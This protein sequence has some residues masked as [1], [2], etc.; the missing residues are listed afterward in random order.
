MESMDAGAKQHSKAYRLSCKQILYT[1]GGNIN[2]LAKEAVNRDYVQPLVKADPPKISIQ[3]LCTKLIHLEHFCKFIR[4]TNLFTKEIQANVAVLIRVLPLWRQSY[5][6]KCIQEALARRDRDC[7]ERITPTHVAGFHSS[8]YAESAQALLLKYDKSLPSDISS[9]DFVRG[10]NYLMTTLCIS[11]A[12]RAGV[13]SKFSMSDYEAG[14]TEYELDPEGNE[15]DIVFT[16]R[17]HKTASTHGAA[18][19][20]VN[21]EERPLLSGY[22]KMRNQFV[23]SEL[24]DVASPL[25]FITTTGGKL[26]QS[27]IAS[28]LTAAF[29]KSGYKKRV[30]CTKLR[31]SATTLVY[32]TNPERRHELASHMLHRSATQEIYYHLLNKK[33]NTVSSTRLL[34]NAYRSVANK[35][36]KTSTIINNRNC[37]SLATVLNQSDLAM[38]AAVKSNSGLETIMQPNSS[39][40]RGAVRSA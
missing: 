4:D 5:R 19:F 15:G 35:A 16:V 14:I 3:T 40:S 30:T 39:L 2:S 6:C 29:I 20:G 10:R 17:D 36:K 12:Q 26:T 33:S 8:L 18:T 27:H 25:V 31:K 28:S 32:K 38:T 22:I 24:D 11:N 23:T 7:L 13:F 37:S 9:R 34:R 1:L 21:S